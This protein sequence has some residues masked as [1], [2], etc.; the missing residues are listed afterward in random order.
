ME[1]PRTVRRLG[2]ISK[3]YDPDIIFIM[4]S[5]NPDDVVLK[6]LQHLRKT[7]DCYHLVPPTG[8]GAGGLGL[9]WKQELNLQ[10]LDSSNHVID[11]IIEFEGK[12]FYSSFIHASTD[13]QQRNLLW[14][15]LLATAAA[16]EAPWFVT[17]DFND[18]TSCHEK[19]GGPDRLEGSFSDLRTFFSEGDLFDLQH[20]GD[21]LSWRGNRCDHLVKCR[22]DRAVSN[23]LWAECFSTARC[24]TSGS[25]LVLIT[26]LCYLSSREVNAEEEVFSGTTDDS[27]KTRKREK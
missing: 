21:F 20:S 2:E 3:K 8:H 12:R 14:D 23:K 10:V 4:E 25:K 16:R 17:G 7:Y 11:T 26:N 24:C 27:A 18:L 1:N 22:L 6:K 15:S 19:D 5:K 13:R 9:F